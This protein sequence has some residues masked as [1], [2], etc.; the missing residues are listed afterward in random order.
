[1][2]MRYIIFDIQLPSGITYFLTEKEPQNTVKITN[3]F[4]KNKK[5]NSVE[6]RK[7]WCTLSNLGNDLISYISA[8]PLFLSMPLSNNK[9]Y[10]C[11]VCTLLSNKRIW[12]TKGKT[13]YNCQ[14]QVCKK[15]DVGEYLNIASFDT[16]EEAESCKSWLELKANRFLMLLGDTEG[17]TYSSYRFVPAPPNGKFDRLFTDNDFYDYFK[18]P[19][20]YIDI[21][22]DVIKGRK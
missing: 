11:K 1:M 21:I 7:T 3:I 15:D 9:Q 16:K 13:V 4:G 22:E 14:T 10:V 6:V 18:I 12:D 5:L 8:Q 20:S 19:P 2:R 17:V